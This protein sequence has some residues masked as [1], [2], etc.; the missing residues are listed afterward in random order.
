[1]DTDFTDFQDSEVDFA[2]KSP[3]QVDLGFFVEETGKEI[4]NV[5]RPS[6]TQCSHRHRCYYAHQLSHRQRQHGPIIATAAVDDVIVCER[7]D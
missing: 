2:Y 7:T 3:G 4:A 5:G 1:M 6:S